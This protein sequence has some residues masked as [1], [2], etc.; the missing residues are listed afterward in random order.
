MH[1]PFFLVSFTLGLIRTHSHTS[2]FSV[3][4]FTSSFF[5]FFFFFFFFLLFFY[6]IVSSFFCLFVSCEQLYIFTGIL[7]V[8][9]RALLS[10]ST[11]TSLPLYSFPPFPSVLLFLSLARNF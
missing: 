4:F 2:P 8:V 7:L 5:F 1:H 6:P 9:V 3:V 11:T 10:T